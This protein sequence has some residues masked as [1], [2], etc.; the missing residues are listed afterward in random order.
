MAV[1]PCSCYAY[2]EVCE[3]MTLPYW[4]TC[5]IHAYEFFGGVTRLLIPDNLKTG[6]TKNTRYETIINKSYYEMAEYYETAVVP[7]RVKKPKDKSHAEGTVSFAT[8]WILAAL[9]NRKF[10]SFD[11]LACAVSEKLVNLNE[12]P[13][14][15]RAGNRFTA[16]QNEE[17]AF[18]KPLP[19]YPYEPAVWSTALV[20]NDYLISD[21]ANKYS[22]P[23]DLIGEHVDI[24]LT[25]ATVEVYFHGS[26]VAS[27][28]RYVSV[29]MDPV[30]KIEHMPDA[31][32]KYLNY[33]SEEF[34][35]WAKDVGHNTVN[36]IESFLGS[37]RVPEEGYKACVSLSKL[38]DKYG[39]ARL[40]KACAKIM[41]ISNTPTIRNIS[42]ILKNGQDRIPSE[43]IAHNQKSHGITRGAEYFR[44]GGDQ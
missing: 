22:V 7:T 43:N 25:K 16:Y 17:K 33:N 29:R 12:I 21:G 5:H 8:T 32:K 40:E 10:L 34:L 1:L 11:E 28:P 19:A 3:E 36:V 41:D 30:V 14:K 26:M 24:K 15:K 27:H 23:F 42:T 2:A 35:R 31:H 9:R 4:L 20:H 39:H 18:M 38:G 6:V 44:K 37:G 13:F